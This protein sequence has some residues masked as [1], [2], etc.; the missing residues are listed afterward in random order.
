MHKVVATPPWLGQEISQYHCRSYGFHIV[1][2]FKSSG[3]KREA[4]KLNGNEANFSSSGSRDRKEYR[5]EGSVKITKFRPLVPCYQAW[6][7]D[8]VAKA[9][10]QDSILAGEVV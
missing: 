3:N 6:K 4:K 10:Q 8:S 7:S 2:Y 1:L 5:N 9:E